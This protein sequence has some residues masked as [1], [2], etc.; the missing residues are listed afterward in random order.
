LR[1]VG[2]REA[3]WSL[4]LLLLGAA[5][6][7]T[8]GCGSSPSE[9]AHD[10]AVHVGGVGV[11]PLTAT[12]V[13]VLEEEKGERSLPIWIGASEASSIASEMN[14]LVPPRPNTHDLAKKILSGLDATVERAVVTDL[15]GGIYFAVLVVFTGGKRLEIDARPSDAIAIAL[16]VHAPLFVREPLFEAADRSDE[17]PDEEALS[18]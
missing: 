13:V 8:A 7:C 5:V 11:D 18:L 9:D 10:V 3:A 16:R 17:G 4:L 6:L 2:P 14:Q 15:Q 12:P 1:P